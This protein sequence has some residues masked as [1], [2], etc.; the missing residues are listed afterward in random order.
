MHIP[1]KMISRIGRSWSVGGQSSHEPTT[2][3]KGSPLPAGSA[4]ATV[5]PE[6]PRRPSQRRGGTYRL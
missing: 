1:P 2:P 5:S 3:P 4:F 6:S